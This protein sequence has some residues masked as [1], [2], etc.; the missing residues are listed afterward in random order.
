MH[1]HARR[2]GSQDS[3][4]AGQLAEP[5]MVIAVVVIELF[6]RRERLIEQ[7]P[8]T[9]LDGIHEGFAG[10]VHSYH[11]LV[12]ELVRARYLLVERSFFRLDPVELELKSVELRPACPGVALAAPTGLPQGFEPLGRIE[13]RWLRG[14][15]FGQL[16]SGLESGDFLLAGGFL[17]LGSVFGQQQANLAPG[18]LASFL[19]FL[20]V[21]FVR[22]LAVQQIVAQFGVVDALVAGDLLDAH[23]F[24]EVFEV[25]LLDP[26]V[27]DEPDD[28]LGGALQVV[29]E[30]GDLRDLALGIGGPHD[31]LAH[32]GV[33]SP[34]LVN[35]AEL[36]EPHVV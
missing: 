21:E 4:E 2:A 6:E 30:H 22:N 12:D 14:G 10:G 18:D 7:V 26:A 35:D 8:G 3:I 5:H 1:F 15:G 34:W 13:R 32:R 16:G 33:V 19:G 29:G 24:V 27:E 9:D 17:P 28:F 20:H 25:V 36:I 23:V 11:L 31:E